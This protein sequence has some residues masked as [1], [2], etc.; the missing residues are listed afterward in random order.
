MKYKSIDDPEFGVGKKIDERTFDDNGHIKS[1]FD[2][3]Y[4]KNLLKDFQI[5]RIRR[6]SGKYQ[7]HENISKYIEVIAKR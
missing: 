2:L 6:S 1:F 5:I 7:G 3:K 4:I